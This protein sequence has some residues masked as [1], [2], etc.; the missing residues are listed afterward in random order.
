MKTMGKQHL[1]AL[2]TKDPPRGRL[3]ASWNNF[4]SSLSNTFVF[5]LSFKK[6][7]KFASFPDFKYKISIEPV[8]FASLL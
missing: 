5:C 6:K 1:R 2:I 3:L 7:R 4:V 8:R